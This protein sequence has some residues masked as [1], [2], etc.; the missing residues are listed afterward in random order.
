MPARKK[1]IHNIQ[2]NYMEKYHTYK[3]RSERRKRALINRLIIVGI[4]FLLLFGLLTFYHIQQRTLHAEKNKQYEILQKQYS[5]L[6][7]EE[8]E[9]REE[10]NLLR[11]ESY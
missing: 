6:K 3:R 5:E 4:T 11:D 7:Q 8:K 10:I 2:S 9:L 1:T